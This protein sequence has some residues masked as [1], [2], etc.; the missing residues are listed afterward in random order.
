MSFLV[1]NSEIVVAAATELE[2]IRSTLEAANAAAPTTRI[3]AAAAD[4]VSTAIASFFATYAQE[5]RALSWQAAAFHAQFIQSLTSS[6]NW[7]ASAEASNVSFL[8]GLEQQ[9]LSLLNAPTQAMLGRPLI[10]DGVDATVPGARG[11]DGGLLFGNGGNGAAGAEAG[12]AGGA[13][14]NAG[15]FGNGGVGGAGG[16]GAPGG[17]GGRGGLV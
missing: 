11:G 16:A 4:E 14:G 7:Y 8:Q 13:G 9:A 3:A 1:A 10:G 5:Y 12:Q 6:V 17:S 15:L 2:G